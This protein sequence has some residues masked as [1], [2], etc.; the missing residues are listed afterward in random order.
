MFSFR[1]LN[2]SKFS[3][4]NISFSKFSFSNFSFSHF[5][6]R[7]N[8]GEG[9]TSCTPHINNKSKNPYEQSSVTEKVHSANSQSH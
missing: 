5:S 1:Q 4:S 9:G 3:F 7:G 6:F 2:F 8:Q